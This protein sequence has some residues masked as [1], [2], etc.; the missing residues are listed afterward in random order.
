MEDVNSRRKGNEKYGNYLFFCSIFLILTQGCGYWF[1]ERE[2]ERDIYVI[3]KHRLVAFCTHPDQGPN[4]KPRDEP[5]QRI[6]PQH[7][8]VKD[9]APG[10]GL[11]FSIK[12]Q[13]LWELSLLF[14]S[15]YTGWA[16]GGLQ[17]WVHETAFTLMLLFIILH[18]NN[19]KPTFVHPCTYNLKKNENGRSYT[20]V[21]N[22][23]KKLQQNTYR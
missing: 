20:K 9:D 13:L 18:M 16:K 1:L 19:C 11:N 6:K 14:K 17:S 5:W 15:I 8:G 22:K 2:E 12:L 10:Q 3:Q 21:K 23:R 4:P 7:L